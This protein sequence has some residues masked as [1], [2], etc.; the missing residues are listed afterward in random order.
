[1]SKFIKDGITIGFRLQSLTLI[2]SAIYLL[3]FLLLFAAFF[4]TDLPRFTQ[5]IDIDAIMS[6]PGESIEDLS[7]ELAELDTAP[8]W[9]FGLYSS[10]VLLIVCLLLTYAAAGTYGVALWWRTQESQKAPPLS[11]FFQYG[12][13]LFN[14]FLNLLGT[15]G[16]FLLGVVV[17]DSLI[18]IGLGL[19]INLTIGKISF[20]L[21]MTFWMLL[22][23]ANF[24]LYLLVMIG[25]LLF[26]LYALSRRV[27]KADPPTSIC[28]DAFQFIR[29]RLSS[30]AALFFVGVILSLA[31]AITASVFF[32]LIDSAIS[33]WSVNVLEALVHSYIAGFVTVYWLVAPYFHYLDEKILE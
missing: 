26:T 14:P 33:H 31:P 15:I 2:H 23:S 8:F 18:M 10:L 6:N 24:I 25:F 3:S 17:I 28:Y 1:L 32:L 21:F 27:D 7:R 29:G 5:A 20:P 16:L 19:L 12:N 9:H 22:W 30:T 4:M 13:R 11:I